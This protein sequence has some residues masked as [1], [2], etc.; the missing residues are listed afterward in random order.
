MVIAIAGPLVNLILAFI[1]TLTYLMMSGD[2]SEVL[3]LEQLM[4]AKGLIFGLALINFTLFFFN[5]IPAYPMDGGR[6]LRALLSIPWGRYKATLWASYIAQFISFLFVIIGYF[7][8]AFTLMLIGIFIFMT[9]RWERRYLIE[10]K[11]LE[12][13]E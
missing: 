1:F 10:E 4:T 12:E 2:P 9:A 6:I 13:E 5:L 3:S 11:H 8:E 7:S